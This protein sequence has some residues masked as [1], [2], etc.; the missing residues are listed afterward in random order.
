MATKKKTS[1][2]NPKAQKIAEL[3]GADESPLREQFAT[4]VVDQLLSTTLGE[5]VDVDE[6]VNLIV[7]AAAGPNVQRA[8]TR[9][10]QP[11]RDRL[12]AHWKKTRERPA[13]LLGADLRVRVERLVATS[14]TPRAAWAKNAVDP[15]LVRQLFAP[16]VQ[17]TLMSFARKL[18]L[19]GIG[20][21]S[22]AGGGG[23]SML[24]GIAGRFKAEVK[25][26]AESFAEK[27]KSLLGG[28]GAQVE[29]QI[30]GVA[31]DFSQGATNEI[32]GALEARLKSPEGV[33][34]AAKIRMQALKRLLETPMI[35]LWKDMEYQPL[36]EIDALS[37]PIAEYNR[38]RGPV[39][40][41]I[42]GE[43]RAMLALE[44]ARTLR[45]LLDEN[46]LLDE[47][48]RIL[49]D[50]VSGQ[51]RAL[52]SSAGFVTWVGALLDAAEA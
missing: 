22:G 43:V 44:G 10:V 38:G 32:R 4:L 16:I 46:G 27:G 52:V 42:E 3:L 28:L 5:L 20:G 26:R 13:D 35:E 25:N 24:G 2:A 33:E 18:P 47:V 48:T 14:P 1:A 30:Q 31:R 12:V 40:E 45:E 51:T 49:L 23:S 29:A 41:F 36:A 7:S 21:D 37:A 19:P 8:V 34:L 11:S 17:D 39:Q 15:A 9:H 50:R 6:T